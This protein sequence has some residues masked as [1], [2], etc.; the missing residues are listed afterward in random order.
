MYFS[1][2]LPP[3]NIAR[4]SPDE[5]NSAELAA[6]NFRLIYDAL[7]LLQL[8]FRLNQ[9]LLHNLL[10]YLLNLRCQRP[11]LPLRELLLCQSLRLPEWLTQRRR[12]L[13]LVAALD[14]GKRWFVLARWPMMLFPLDRCCPSK[15]PLVWLSLPNRL[16]RRRHAPPLQ[17]LP[18]SDL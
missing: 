8:L 14:L 13:L 15:H 7:L 10:H 2:P 11:L 5:P 12:P 16:R 4:I 3:N 18:A 1:I 6:F 17:S 9:S